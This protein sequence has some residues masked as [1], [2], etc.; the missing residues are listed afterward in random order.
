[1]VSI[2]RLPEHR[3]EPFE[4]DTVDDRI[5]D[6]LED[7]SGN[8]LADGDETDPTHGK[9]GGDRLLACEGNS[10]GSGSFLICGR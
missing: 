6:R 8:G 10:K 4:A 9:L 1:M 2:V 3:Q 7:G 5:V